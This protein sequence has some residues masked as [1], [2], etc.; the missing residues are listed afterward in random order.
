VLQFAEVPRL[1]TV[2]VNRPGWPPLGAGE[3]ATPVAAAALANAVRAATGVRA[4]E[5][6][7]AG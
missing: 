7:L 4:R 3:A 2:L 5:L 6:P 1:E